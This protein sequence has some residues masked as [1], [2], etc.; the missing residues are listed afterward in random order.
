MLKNINGEQLHE[1]SFQ[2]TEKS[3]YSAYGLTEKKKRN[4][5]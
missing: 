2:Y 3:E 4:N 5:L 1:V